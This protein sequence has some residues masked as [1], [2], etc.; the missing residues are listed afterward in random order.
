M[1]D[2]LMLVSCFTVANAPHEGHVGGGAGLMELSGIDGHQPYHPL[3]GRCAELFSAR[4]SDC[5]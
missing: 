5:G 3:L 4:D 1:F 2:P